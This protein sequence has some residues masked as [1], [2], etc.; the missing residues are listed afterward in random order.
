MPS[1][2]T[3]RCRWARRF[4][5]ERLHGE[6]AHLEEPLV[7]GLDRHGGLVGAERREHGHGARLAYAGQPRDE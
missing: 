2:P 5:A 1:M 7:L 4:V 3:W 6:L